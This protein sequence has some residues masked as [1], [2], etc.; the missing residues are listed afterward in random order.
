MLRQAR[1]RTGEK[2]L[3]SR[4]SRRDETAQDGPPC[5]SALP[6]SSGRYSMQV[7]GRVRGGMY[8]T[9]V[10]VVDGV[11]TGWSGRFG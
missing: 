1:A 9:S 3:S 4:S 2:G 11:K 10:R 7:V 8:N 6:V 5:D